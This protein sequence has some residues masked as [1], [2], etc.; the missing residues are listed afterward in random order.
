MSIQKHTTKSIIQQFKKLF[1][2]IIYSLVRDAQQQSCSTQLVF[3][4]YIIEI[5]IRN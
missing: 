4:M 3:F 1:T 2:K 5:Y